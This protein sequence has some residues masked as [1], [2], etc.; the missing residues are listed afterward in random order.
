MSA[1]DQNGVKEVAPGRLIATLGSAGAMAGFLLVFVFVATEP[2]IKAH[3]AK[4]LRESI[5]EVLSGPQQFDTLFELEE[6]ALVEELPVGEDPEKT[7]QIYPGFDGNGGLI[8][9]AIVSQDPGFQDIVKVIFGYNAESQQVLGMK[10][11][12]SKETPGLGDK[13]EKD[14]SWVTAFQGILAPI[15][16]VKVGKNTGDAHE[17]DMITGATISSK[18]VIRIIND[19][20]E[21]YGPLIEAYSGGGAQ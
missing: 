11:L 14:M 10:V 2:S 19:A 18:A 17:I 1:E 8:G 4:V 20:I 3:K 5:Q 6:G 9:Y 21:H 16:G 15:V 7:P 12:E 13:I